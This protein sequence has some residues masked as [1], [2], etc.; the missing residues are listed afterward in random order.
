MNAV[1]D[2]WALLLPSASVLLAGVQ[3][4]GSFVC[5]CV[6]G[7]LAMWVLCLIYAGYYLRRRKYSEGGWSG[8]HVASDERDTRPGVKD[9]W[10]SANGKALR[11]QNVNPISVDDQKWPP[12]ISYLEFA[13]GVL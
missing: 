1:A 11:V 8:V 6:I 2:A 12:L 13:L 10:P 9:S 5:F 4:K 3:R 7:G